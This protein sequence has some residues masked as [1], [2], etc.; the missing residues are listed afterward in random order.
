MIIQLILLVDF[1]H[2]WNES[3]LAKAE[4]GSKCH[5]FGV[6][7]S[8]IF[9]NLFLCAHNYF[10]LNSPTF[11]GLATATVLMYLM[12]FITTVLLYVYYTKHEG[13]SCAENKFFISFNMILC[14]VCMIASVNGRVQEGKLCLQSDL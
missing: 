9:I 7:L 4:E 6:L 14:L 8:L 2:S 13:E 5:F 11:S 1:A 3:W 12:S 10:F